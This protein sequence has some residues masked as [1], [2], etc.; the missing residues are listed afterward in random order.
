MKA[1]ILDR[2][3]ENKA[4]CYLCSISLADY[5][6]GLP[7][8][9]RD[10]DIQREIVSNVYLDRLVETVLLKAHIP[11]IVL[12]VGE[13]EFDLKGPQLEIKSFKILDGLQRTFRLEA[14]HAT[15]AFTVDELWPPK[16]YLDWNKFK[17]SREFSERL[18]DINSN[19][20]VLRAVLTFGEKSGKSALLDVLIESTV[21]RGLDRT[22]YRGRN[23]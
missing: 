12:V 22:L 18:R 17:L 7:P 1:R 20:D 13:R 11:P 19:T 23:T 3:S 2:R 9:Y 8:T 6:E 10:Y 15:I 16:K 21:V 5:V 14:I 4:S